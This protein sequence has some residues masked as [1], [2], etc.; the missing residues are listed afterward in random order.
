MTRV[1]VLD[2]RFDRQPTLATG[3][4]AEDRGQS[5]ASAG[6]GVS[7]SRQDLVDAL[8]R[9]GAGDQAA[10]RRV[11]A[12]TSAKLFG[13]ILRILGQRD[14]AEDVLQDVYIR[15]WQRAG[16]FD[17]AVSSP[18]SW[19]VAIARNRALDETRRKTN[20]S[21][22]DC[23]ELLQTPSGDNPLAEYE[24]KEER[25]RLLACLDRLEP[26]KREVIV[27]AYHYGMTREEIGRTIK[28]PTATVKTWLRRGLAQI[29]DCLGQ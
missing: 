13:I 10:F 3:R 22:E 17:P 1:T 9:S 6:R 27:R 26:D 25:L 14:L 4:A 24:Q 12:S 2:P 28:R 21:L 18:I 11:Y 16:D 8:K 7:S 20:R 5:N 23:P 19:L 15:V 29:R